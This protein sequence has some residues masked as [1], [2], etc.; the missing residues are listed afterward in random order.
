MTAR[1]YQNLH[2]RTAN[3]LLQRIQDHLEY[4]DACTDGWQGWLAADTGG[5]T[6]WWEPDEPA[7]QSLTARAVLPG[8][9]GWAHSPRCLTLPRPPG[10]TIMT[11]EGP[12][13]QVLTTA[14]QRQCLPALGLGYQPG[15]VYEGDFDDDQ[16]PSRTACPSCGGLEIGGLNDPDIQAVLHRNAVIG[17]H[18]NNLRLLVDASVTYRSVHASETVPAVL[19]LLEQGRQALARAWVR[20]AD[21]ALL[22]ALRYAAGVLGDPAAAQIPVEDLL[23]LVALNANRS[24][25]QGDVHSTGRA[26]LE[27][28]AL[29]PVQG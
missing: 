13:H 21:L 27:L 6:R 26:L 4:S 24:D 10:E 7:F 12:L 25:L 20:R 19:A 23:T 28:R 14:V 1:A 9:D 29:P 17:E 8:E 5:L 22:E 15:V 18:L 16:D 11:V 3:A 2:Q